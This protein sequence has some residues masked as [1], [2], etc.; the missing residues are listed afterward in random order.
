[1]VRWVLAAVVGVFVLLVLSRRSFRTS[2][3]RRLVAALRAAG[4]EVQDERPGRLLLRGPGGDGP[5]FLDR[6]YQAVAN[7]GSGSTDEQVDEVVAHWVATILEVRATDA[8]LTQAEDGAR[9]L[10]RLVTPAFFDELP[11]DAGVPHTPLGQTGLVVVYVL[12]L[13]RSV[14]FLTAKH[15]GELG[16]DRAGAHALALGNLAGRTPPDVLRGLTERTEGVTV[17][18]TGDTY[19]AARLLL[20]PLHVPEGEARLVVVP[21]RDSLVVLADDG[22]EALRAAH[23]LARL[24]GGE[25]PLFDRPLRVTRE[26]VTLAS[27][28]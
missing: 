14:S 11:P 28:G 5:L 10:P 27:K 1:V 18:K 6:Y 4:V 21:D 16:L 8:P 13:E 24:R 3:R 22:A 25:R 9:V 17:L 15:L 7:L 26:G 2:A 12:D 20:L 19:D 23:E